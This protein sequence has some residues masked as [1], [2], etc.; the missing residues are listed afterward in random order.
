MLA[1]ISMGLSSLKAASDVAKGLNAANTQ[2][3]INDIKISLQA[4]IL[5]AQQALTSAQEAQTACAQRIR[6]L[7]KQI[8]EFETWETEKERYELTERSLT[9]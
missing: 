3:L 5:E 6:D 8:A 2:T 1:E 7:E 4:H 9:A